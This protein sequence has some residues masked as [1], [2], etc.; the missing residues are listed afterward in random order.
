MY[1][2]MYVYAHDESAAALFPIISPDGIVA[3][4]FAAG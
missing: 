3:T 2:C 4:F 1:A